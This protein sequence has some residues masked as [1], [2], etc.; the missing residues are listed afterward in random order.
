MTKRKRIIV[1]GGSFNPPTLAH[2]KLMEEAV[3]TLGANLGFFVPVSDAYLKRKM[4]HIHPPV[5]LSPDMRVRM[6]RT[7]CQEDTRLQVCE[8]EIGT[9]EPRTMPTLQ[10][11]QKDYPDAE[12]FFV[13]GA[14]KLSLLENLTRKRRFL[15]DFRA[16]LYSREDDA[17]ES[18]L[19]NNEVLGNYL[20]RIVILPQPKETEGI[21][22]S[23]VRERMLSGM[24]C[25]DLLC[26]GVWE[27]FKGFT[28]ADFPDV[29][30]SFKGEFDFMN[31]RYTSHFVWHDVR[32]R[33]A[34]EAYQASR[35]SDEERVS[36]MSLF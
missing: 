4:R 13:M 2:F 6:L 21:S 32:Y 12:L 14:D 29:I 17:L 22:S 9:I 5:V 18:S 3:C 31:N 8:K 23:K 25:Q 7:M 19:S 35:C 11:L 15:D 36:T 1:M 27:L 30:C 34:E 33:S 16:V 10:A 26:P 28:P 24:S 20:N